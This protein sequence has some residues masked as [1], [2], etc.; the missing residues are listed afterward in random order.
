MSVAGLKSES[1][2]RQAKCRG[3]L[4]FL[5]SADLGLV[6]HRIQLYFFI[7]L[8]V[9]FGMEEVLLTL[10]THPQLLP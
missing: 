1:H 4:L 2:Y 9:P 6:S 3:S 8:I 5:S 7:T 10:A